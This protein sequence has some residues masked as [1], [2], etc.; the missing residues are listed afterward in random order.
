VLP[1]NLPPLTVSSLEKVNTE[2]TAL[3]R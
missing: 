3:Q 1:T 2:L